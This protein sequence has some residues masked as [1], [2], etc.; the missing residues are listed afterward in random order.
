MRIYAFIILGVLTIAKITVKPLFRNE[1]SPIVV[2]KFVK[3]LEKKIFLLLV[4]ASIIG[5]LASFNHLNY[6]H[7]LLE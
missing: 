7:K 2:S 4:A 5:I 3:L 1:P 6:T